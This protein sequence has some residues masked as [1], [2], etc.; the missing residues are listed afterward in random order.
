MAKRKRAGLPT[1]YGKVP[2]GTTLRNSWLVSSWSCS[3]GREKPNAEHPENQQN[4]R[5]YAEKYIQAG[6]E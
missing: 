4:Q 5:K 3:I 2:P 6:A 1:R